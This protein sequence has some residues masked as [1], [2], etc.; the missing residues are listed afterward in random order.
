MLSVICN[1]MMM[2]AHTK[3]YYHYYYH[4][5]KYLYHKTSENMKTMMKDENEI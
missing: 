1:V 2:F 3:D 5:I 4:Q